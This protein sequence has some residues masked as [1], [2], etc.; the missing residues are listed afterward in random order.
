MSND[1]KEE[2]SSHTNVNLSSQQLASNPKIST[3]R[4]PILKP[5]GS[6]S[7][8]LN[9]KKVVLRVLKTAKV[10]HVL[11]PVNVKRRPPTWEEDNDL[12]CA[13]LVQI[14]DEA[15]LRHLA[16]ED[17][18]SKIWNDLSK[19]HQDS[20][21]GGRIYWIRKLL[22]TRMEGDDMN[23]HLD[24]LANYY[25]RLNALITPE[26]PLTAEDVHNA[27]ILSSIPPDW[28]SCVSGLMNQEDVKTEKY[29]SALKNKS[30]RRETQGDIVSV[31]LTKPTSSK[32]NQS[33]NPSKAPRGDSSKKPRRC[34]LCNCDSH[35][36]NSCNNTRKLIAEHKAAQKAHWEA[37]QQDKS[38]P[39]TKPAAR[40][41]RTSAATLGQS[42]HKYDEDEESDYSGSEIDVTAGNAVVSLSIPSDLP[43]VRL[44]DHSTVE[45]SHKGL[46]KLPLTGDKSVKSLVVPSLHEPLLSV[47]A[48]CDEGFTV[49]F[50]KSSC[51][52]LTTKSTQVQGDL[53]GRGYRRGNLYYLPSEPVS[54]NSSL[55]LYPRPSDHS[56]M[57]YHLRFSHIGVKP[58][59]A[60][61]KIHDITP[62]VMNK[63]EVQRCPVCVQT[64]MPCKAFKSRAS[65]RSSI[66]GEIIHSDVGSY[67]TVS[68]EGYRYFITFVDDCSKSLSI[69]PMKYKSDSFACFKIFCAFFE[70]DG[71]HKI[72]SLR[73]D[74]G[75]E[76]IS[77]EFSSYLSQA[78]I[79]HEPGPPHSPEL[80]GVAERT[81]RTISNLVRSS[82]LTANLPKSFWVDAIQHFMFSYNSFPCHTPVG[83]KPPVS[84]LKEKPVDV[85]SVHPFGCLVWYKI[86]EADRK[87]LDRKGRASVLLS[88]L[89]D[90][91][92]YR[93]WDLEKR[94]VVKS[95]DVIFDDSSFPYGCKLNSPPA[96]QAVEIDWP[97]RPPEPVPPALPQHDPMPVHLQPSFDR[98]LTASIHAP[99]NAP[100]EPSPTC[101]NSD[102]TY[103]P[104][105]VSPRLPSTPDLSIISLPPSPLFRRH[106]LP[107]PSPQ[108][109]R[110][111]VPRQSLLHRRKKSPTPPPK[112]PSPPTPPRRR[113]GR[114][115]KAP[116]RYGNWAKNASADSDVDT[117]KTWRQ[118]LKS[119]KKHRWLKAAEEEFASLLGMQ[120]WRLVP[121]P[122]KRRIIKSKWVFKVK[123]RPD[124]TIQ[125]LKA[126]LV[127]MGYS[128]IQGLDYDEVFSPT[129]RLETL[130]LIFSLLATRG[131][132]GRQVDFKTAFLN[133]HLDKPVFMEQP[134]GF[135]D[136]Q[137]PDWVCEVNRSLYGLK[138]SP[139]QWNIE[140]HK[141][142]LNLGLTNSKYDP[143]LY[144]K[145]SSGSLVGALTT[146]VDDL[147]I[148]GE[149]TFV[150]S[151][152]TEM[153]K[154]F[155]IGADEEL[156]H[157][158][159]LKITRDIPNKHIFLN[160]S[161]Y[162]NEICN[163]FLDGKH[164]SVP[165]PTNVNFK[166]L[167]HRSVSEPPSSG[168]YPQLIGSLL[169]VSQ[170]TRP[171]VS[172]AVNRLSQYLRDP[173]DAHWH[174]GLRILNYLVTTKDLRLR[175]GGELALLGYS[176][177]DWAE[178]RDD[179][180]SMSA[181]TY[182]VGDGAISWKSRKQATVSL[183]STEAEYKALSD[184]CKEGLW[185]QHLL[186]KLH[187]R[188]DTA[189]PLHVDNEG[190]E[191][192][193]KNPAH[194]AR[195][196]HIHARY[197][198]IRECVQ[199]GDITL[200]HVST[201]EMLADMLTKPLPR[202]ALEKHRS[203]FGIV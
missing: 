89:S 5:P 91:N 126:R 26:K 57:A 136:P 154:H 193:A 187:L 179:R 142:L 173:S 153:G 82:L 56:L 127:A 109:R 167:K 53:A 110:R 63:I 96:P 94:S 55:S 135:E 134:P 21:S 76:Y 133:G 15:N 100:R 3:A 77:N 178:D 54:S 152:I 117:P 47:A 158:L 25:E 40:A 27:A 144:F 50:T 149:P 146:H 112:S 169:W 52:F 45:A 191:A 81:N 7:N 35:D 12:V 156:S 141:A 202:V 80:N 59:K 192:L 116:D 145:L 61:L 84:I 75:G 101:S 69:Y 190:A 42:S 181:Y 186:T 65:H 176:D 30:V 183:S 70:R 131:W 32:P 86:P 78:G 130:R 160:Q 199:E 200:L 41:D 48:L 177:S 194:H 22:G 72:L 17:T 165:T 90:G 102:S 170:C 151:I 155:K 28:I 13:V 188:P 38:S 33:S 67:E 14:V 46:L 171:D 58:L 123:R 92:G 60:F 115:R 129:L 132:K 161:H 195:T 36:L 37:S 6:D 79:K 197:H 107:L 29:V 113:S 104:Q 9:W 166:N 99:G 74:N 66:P 87:K 159:S 201:K 138:Q 24:T 184:S 71:R 157:F 85:K 16:D 124:H 97:Q 105:V 1:T 68:R 147:A 163:R 140:L 34:P 174:A 125:K 106:L 119:P 2:S 88:Y 93:L 18:A 62:T 23:S 19:A 128:Q 44:A 137:H 111:T 122:A 4:L 8:Y 185:L 73:T 168:P 150:D 83:F 95:R 120:T 49:V 143:T 11:T 20:S 39:S 64:K 98:R 180:Y 121:R 175:L 182:C 10:N 139:R 196:K 43:Q 172:F 162:I 51:D 103:S 164:T 203:M 114:E 148:V 198:F 108:P 31:S 118:L 189:I